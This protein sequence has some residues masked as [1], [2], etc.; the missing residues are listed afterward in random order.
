MPSNILFSK[1]VFRTI[2]LKKKMDLPQKNEVMPT[3]EL[4]RRVLQNQRTL[5]EQNDKLLKQQDQQAMVEK[6]QGRSNLIKAPAFVKVSR[7]F[8]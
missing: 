4:L 2:N 6:E 1:L 7:A 8:A 3:K 5:L